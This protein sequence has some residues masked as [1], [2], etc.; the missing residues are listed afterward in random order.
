MRMIPVVVVFLL[1][2]LTKS[3]HCSVP[4]VIN[5]GCDLPEC[6]LPGYPA[7]FYA[8]HYLADV[9]IH[10]LYSSLDELTI[11]IIQTKKGYGPHLNYTALFSGN[12]SG[13]IS[14]ADTVPLNSFSLIARRLMQFDDK[15]DTGIL[16]ENDASIQSYW[17]NDLHTNLTRDN[18]NVTQPSFQ[19]P[20][21]NIT[22]LLTIDINY[23]GEDTRDTK[24]PKLRSSPKSY[25][26]NIALQA[27]NITSKNTRFAME[28]YLIQ[29]GVEGTQLSTSKYIDDQYT[30]GIFNVWQIK[31][32]SPIYSSSMLW[33]PVVYQSADRSIEKNTL[34]TVYDLKNNISLDQSIDQGI[35]K[36]LYNKTYVSAF[37]VSLGRANDG[38]FVK[39][40]YS[41]IQFTAGL[42]ILEMDS[43]KQFVTLA[44]V[45]S[46][47]LPCLVAFIAL[48]FI[49][50]RRC[51]RSNTA[52]YDAIDD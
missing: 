50:K 11:S 19:L 13:A 51:S 21:K 40:N 43:I 1:T 41:F 5:P 2:V 7:I 22:G 26:L 44:L 14:F 49:M 36:A 18:K 46:L 10:I 12:Y 48:I 45:F 16:N 42:D 38:F 8:Y 32:R 9:T 52:G 37:N 15:N 4:F 3:S 33:K 35:F 39:S 31:S 30:P 47:L 17:L 34:M 27:D 29:L 6:L 23:P 20:L 24:F 28:Y 25:F